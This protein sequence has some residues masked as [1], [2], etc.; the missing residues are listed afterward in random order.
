MRVL[1][2]L[3]AESELNPKP[4]AVRTHSSKTNISPNLP[5]RASRVYARQHVTN[6]LNNPPPPPPPPPPPF[7]LTELEPP[8][9]LCIASCRYLTRES[10]FVNSLECQQFRVSTVW[11]VNSLECQQLRESATWRLKSGECAPT[12]EAKCVS[13][14]LTPVYLLPIILA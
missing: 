11:S 14:A 9:L 7:F 6:G 8:E 2:T 12:F 5:G 3:R 1:Y 4:T 10:Q 13:L